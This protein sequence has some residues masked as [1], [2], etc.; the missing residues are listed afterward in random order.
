MRRAAVAVA[1][2]LTAPARAATLNVGAFAGNIPIIDVSGQIVSGDDQRFKL[3]ADALQFAVVRLDS[4]GGQ[5]GTAINIGLVI[6]EK[7]YAT[8][9]GPG[10]LCASACS[11]AWLAGQ[12]H[13]KDDSAM[14]GFHGAFVPKDG[15]F[16]PS[17]PG[18]AAIGAYLTTLHFDMKAVIYMTTALPDQ[19][20]WLTPQI[21]AAYDIPYEGRREVETTHLNAAVP[22]TEARLPPSPPRAPTRQEAADAPLFGRPAASGTS[23]TDE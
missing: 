11:L 3:L 5:I 13:A 15:H 10:R 19:M 16:E 9:V 23:A 20:S 18:N 8:Y 7:G 2:L 12:P 6:H 14:I 17:A 21:A 4:R 1:L 22:A